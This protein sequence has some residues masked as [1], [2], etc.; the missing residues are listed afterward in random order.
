MVVGIV[1][2]VC[3]E[4]QTS[5]VQ[6]FQTSIEEINWFIIDLLRYMRLDKRADFYCTRLYEVAPQPVSALIGLAWGYEADRE[7][8]LTSEKEFQKAASTM[9]LVGTVPDRLAGASWG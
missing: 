5:L 1:S 3:T 4:S 7:K 8:G 2:F 9:S 6:L